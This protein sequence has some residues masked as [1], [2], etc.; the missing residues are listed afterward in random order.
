MDRLAQDGGIL[1]YLRLDGR[2]AGLSA[3]V[4]ATALELA[5]VDT[6]TSRISIGVDPE[7]RDFASVAR[8]LRD[9][10]IQRVR[11]LTNNPDK[12][13]ALRALG[14]SVAREPI[15]VIPTNDHVKRLY[16]TK[17]ERFG[18]HL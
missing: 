8:Y 12:A 15:R 6:W 4:A 11:L 16:I 10:G 1:V 3:K 14:I 13:E 18:H 9:R 7:S 2:G 17:A 5:G